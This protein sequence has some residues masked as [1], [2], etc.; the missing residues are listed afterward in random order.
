MVSGILPLLH[1]TLYCVAFFIVSVERHL[2]G[3]LPSRIHERTISFF[4]SDLFDW[5]SL[6]FCEFFKKTYNHVTRHVAYL[7]LKLQN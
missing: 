7:W 3:A 5:I 1:T 4:K 6:V 2:S